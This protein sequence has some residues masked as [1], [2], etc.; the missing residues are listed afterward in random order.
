MRSNPSLHRAFLALLLPGAWALL[1]AGCGGGSAD[2]PSRRAL[3]ADGLAAQASSVE[4]PIAIFPGRGELHQVVR[5]ADFT[6]AD[7]AIAAA[8]PGVRVAGAVPRYD[9]QAWRISYRT[10]D[11]ANQPIVASGL[12]AVPVK[13]AGSVSPV[14]GYQ[15]GTIFKDAEAPSNALAPDEPPIVLASLGFIVLAADYVG[16]GVSKGAPH[17][18]LLSAPTAAAVNDLLIAA[19]LWRQGTAHRGNGQLFLVGYSEGGYAT[20]AAHR[21][22]TQGAGPLRE[23]LV[24]SIA[25]GGPQDVGTTLDRLLARVKDR[26]ILLGALI[27]PGF[28]RHLGSTVREEVRRAMLREIIP[29][30]ADVS[31][32]STFLDFFLADDVGSIERHCNVLDWVPEVPYRL[33]HGRDD[34]TVTYLSSQNAVARAIA[35]GAAPGLVT[36]ADCAAS[37]SD[38]LPCVNPFFRYTT[39]YLHALAR[40]L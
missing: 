26:N 14:L 32:Q 4:P 24:A 15:H 6:Q 22:I 37:P 1:L 13:P 5:L 16:Y 17:P 10:V 20:A 9:V 28:L 33:F 35:A 25:G 11:G 12:M 40:D 27:N 18:Y 7:I 19:R 34:G 21:E 39:E 38:H 23:T 3:G 8:V 31:F 29:G 2:A 30:D 36:L